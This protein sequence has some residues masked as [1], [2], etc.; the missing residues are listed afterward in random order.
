MLASISTFFDQYLK[1]AT[2]QDDTADEHA[3]Q[4]ATAALLLEMCHSDQ[5]I[6]ERETEKL[7]DI[8]RNQ[9]QLAEDELEQLLTLADDEARQATSLYQFTSLF[10]EAWGY[11]QKLQLISQLW[12]VAYADGNLDRYEEH[13]IRKV[14]DLLYVSHSDF[15]RCKLQ[16][17]ERHNPD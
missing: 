12:E 3:L 1:P 13:L 17:R 15:I 9:Y 4:L 11:P 14:A 6:D 5:N 10:N 2:E 8:L 16:V 7:L